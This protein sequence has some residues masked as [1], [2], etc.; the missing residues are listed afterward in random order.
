MESLNVLVVEDD[1]DVRFLVAAIFRGVGHTVREAEHGQ[2]ALDVL[3]VEQWRPDV[4]VLDVAMPVMDGL[5]FLARKQE[6]ED[7]CA[8]PVVIVSATA[9]PPIQ[10]ARCVLPKPVEA[11]ELVR[12]VHHH[13]A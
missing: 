8:I 10:G 9:R 12:A 5:T 11:E 2:D 6:A 13:A 3:Q 4:I 7:L 1:A